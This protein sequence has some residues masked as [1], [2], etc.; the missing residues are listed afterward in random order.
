M[1]EHEKALC[2]KG[3]IHCALQA[4][5]WFMNYS[6]LLFGREYIVLNITVQ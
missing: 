2:N 5:I 1:W 6:I 3:S 4:E